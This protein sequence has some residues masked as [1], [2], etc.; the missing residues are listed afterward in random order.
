MVCCLTINLILL[1][2]SDRIIS[3]LIIFT[4]SL[5]LRILLELNNQI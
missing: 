4:T 3:V 5:S 2:M 1:V